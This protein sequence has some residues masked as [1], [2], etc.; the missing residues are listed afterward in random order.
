[1]PTTV[2]GL[3]LDLS[4]ASFGMGL[5]TSDGIRLTLDHGPPHSLSGATVR[6]Q[7]IVL[8]AQSFEDGDYILSPA[9]DLVFL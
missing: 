2:P 4:S 5:L 3:H 6:I 7:A 1:V 9:L 8:D